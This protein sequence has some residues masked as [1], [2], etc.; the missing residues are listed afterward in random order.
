MFGI[1]LMVVIYTKNAVGAAR[2]RDSK[3]MLRGIDTADLRFRMSEEDVDV[4]WGTIIG[5]LAIV[6]RF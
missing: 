1:G 2:N 4:G 5:S 6:R 3:L